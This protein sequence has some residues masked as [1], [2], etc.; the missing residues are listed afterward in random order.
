MTLPLALN[1]AEALQVD[2]SLALQMEAIV[3][4]ANALKYVRTMREDVCLITEQP[5]ADLQV[6]ID[7]TIVS[8]LSESRLREEIRLLMSLANRAPKLELDVGIEVRIANIPVWAAQVAYE[9]DGLVV[10]MPLVSKWKEHYLEASAT[11]I[12]EDGEVCSVEIRLENL[13]D[14]ASCEEHRRTIQSRG[15][16]LP[17]GGA[18]E[19]WENRGTIFPGLR[20]LGS[21]ESDLDRVSASGAGL[22]QVFN[23]L[24]SINSSARRWK[25]REVAYP[26][27]TAKVTPESESRRP[28]CHFDDGNGVSRLYELHARFTPGAGRIHFRTVD[29]D[30]VVE[31]AY[32]GPKIV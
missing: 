14:A 15:A 27:W 31:I 9:C 4:C 18:K 2:S 25:A 12:S 3:A 7:R 21:V 16:G 22:L 26:E 6:S 13:H 10:S 28:M 5:F 19:I 32:I 24:S 11:Q 29:E 1:I 8:F 17:I 30:R 20:F 23:R